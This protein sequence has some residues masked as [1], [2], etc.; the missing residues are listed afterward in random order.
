MERFDIRFKISDTLLGA[1]YKC[2]LR[3]SQRRSS[4]ALKCSSL[5]VA[6]EL[7]T[8]SLPRH[9]DD[10]RRE[11][12]VVEQLIA[13]GGHRHVVQCYDQFQ[14]FSHRLSSLPGSPGRRLG[15]PTRQHLQLE[16]VE[17]WMDLSLRSIK[18]KLERSLITNR[19][20]K[21]TSQSSEATK[22]GRFKTC[23]H[24]TPARQRQPLKNRS[25]SFAFGPLH[26][27]R[28]AAAVAPLTMRQCLERQRCRTS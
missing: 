11:W 26:A 10:P 19:S 6:D 7:R 25:V 8:R 22:L 9:V 13:S 3:H 5:V 2:H 15:R 17:Q 28:L 14:L 24:L 1:V 20:S 16:V 18:E 4:V 21:R 23:G 12:Q 27:R